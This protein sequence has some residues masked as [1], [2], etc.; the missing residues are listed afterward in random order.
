MHIET[1]TLVI[2]G[3]NDSMEEQENL[4][5]WVVENLGPDTPMHFSAFHPDYRMTDRGATPVALLEGS[6][7]GKRARAPV[8]VLGNVAHHPFEKPTARPA[9]PCLSNAGDFRAGLRASTTGRCT[10]CG[11]TI[12]IVRHVA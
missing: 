2:P 1:V 12:G 11:E 8:P 6:L 9:A 4:I 5:R 10:S 7:T 3:L